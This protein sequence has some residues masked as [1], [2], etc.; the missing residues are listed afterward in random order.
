MK[1]INKC[2]QCL[3]YTLKDICQKCGAKTIQP[4]PPKYS[5]E[6]KYGQYRREE[7]KQEFKDKGLI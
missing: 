2:T 1:H 3:T 7:K 4:K 5:P 6:D